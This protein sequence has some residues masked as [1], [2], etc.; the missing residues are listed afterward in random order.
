M[1]SGTGSDTFLFA[2]FDIL[3]WHSGLCHQWQHTAVIVRKTVRLN[4]YVGS[5]YRFVG[6]VLLFCSVF[7]CKT[8][9]FQVLSFSD[10]L[11]HPPSLRLG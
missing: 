1:A 11:R 4:F 2:G 9:Q 7:I 8:D 6:L 10:A 5:R 3:S